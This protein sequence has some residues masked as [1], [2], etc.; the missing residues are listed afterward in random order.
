M[1]A[2]K[3]GRGTS[4]PTSPAGGM[5]AVSSG[6]F[7]R[8]L[9]GPASPGSSISGSGHDLAARRALLQSAASFLA[10]PD[11][12]SRQ[13][14]STA[15][16]LGATFPARELSRSLVPPAATPAAAHAERAAAVAAAAAAEEEARR[17]RLS[18][19][20]I[21][22]LKKVYDTSGG[23]CREDRINAALASVGQNLSTAE[24][25]EL[26]EEAGYQRGTLGL[27]QWLDMMGRLKARFWAVAV[28]PD[29]DTVEAFVSLSGGA[30]PDGNSTPE[31]QVET[32]RLRQV[33]K[34]FQL[35][36]D[37]DHLI[38][39]I[40][41][42]GSGIVDYREFRKMVDG[43][44]TEGDGAGDWGGDGEHAEPRRAKSAQPPA[45]VRSGLP[46]GRTLGRAGLLGSRYAP[47][48]AAEI[49]AVPSSPKDD[50]E[51]PSS[52]LSQ[53]RRY[54]A[55]MDRVRDATTEWRQMLR[56][57]RRKR[58][59][60]RS[61]FCNRYQPPAREQRH[62]EKDQDRDSA[63]GTLRGRGHQRRASA[64]SCESFPIEQG[65]AEDS[66][67]TRL[68]DSHVYHPADVLDSLR[69]MLRQLEDSS[70]TPL[71]TPARQPGAA[72]HPGS[73]R[74]CPGVSPNVMFSPRTTRRRPRT[75]VRREP[76]P[77]LSPQQRRQRAAVARWV[78]EASED[79][80]MPQRD[81]V[82]RL[83]AQAAEEYRGQRPRPATAAAGGRAA[84][85]ARRQHGS[86]LSAAGRPFSAPAAGCPRAS[87]A[88]PAAPCHDFLSSPDTEE[89][90]VL[91]ADD[92][93]DAGANP[94]A[95][96]LCAT[97][98]A[99]A[100]AA[101]A[102]APKRTGQRGWTAKD[103][104]ASAGG[105][106]KGGRRLRLAKIYAQPARSGSRRTILW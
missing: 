41:A 88:Q 57:G 33:V 58:Y 62:K 3:P 69:S 59:H 98:A 5:L 14:S 51:H 26:L 6:T 70:P 89:E 61:R 9:R 35:T 36:V 47:T 86:Q 22:A 103:W 80:A 90:V 106:T 29:G 32:D 30:R 8:G 79:Y 73:P 91:S 74:R 24:M 53:L 28:Q 68:C 93:V 48:A 23:L 45:S 95:A 43:I 75:A 56:P 64:S 15:G 77:L 7:A 1:A 87:G 102:A 55:K 83:V 104:L 11:A 4:R 20:E 81:W 12:G 52:F 38:Q 85:A 19:R 50:Q 16:L 71:Q 21:A 13:G 67:W 60:E 44:S 42:D 97:A 92:A 27:D 10:P 105:Q 37:I 46:A 25:R 54:E 2:A 78:A 40:D 84:A 94:A 18:A 82:A 63:R 17:S 96:V 72:S 49:I 31:G 66:I 76:A 101:A 34:D 65:E 99:F 100:A 39:E